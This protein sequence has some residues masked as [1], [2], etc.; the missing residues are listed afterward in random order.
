MVLSHLIIPQEKRFLAVFDIH[1]NTVILHV[2]SL[3]TFIELLFFLIQKS[4][5][6][7]ISTN[8]VGAKACL[9]TATRGSHLKL[10]SSRLVLVKF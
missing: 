8:M 5:A 6:K 10:N 2:L 9:T 1:T 4:M 3:Q 7:C